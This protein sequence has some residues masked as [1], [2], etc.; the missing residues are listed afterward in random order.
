MTEHE[1]AVERHHGAGERHAVFEHGQWVSV[2]HDRAVFAHTRVENEGLPP[3]L[4]EA[5]VVPA[6]EVCVVE[7]FCVGLPYH[8]QYR[9]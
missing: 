5:S 4:G 2:R 9:G 1:P 8:L 6:V 7:G 3:R